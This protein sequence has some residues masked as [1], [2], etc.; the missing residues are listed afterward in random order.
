MPHDSFSCSFRNARCCCGITFDGPEFPHADCNLLSIIPSRSV[1]TGTNTNFKLKALVR[2]KFTTCLSKWEFKQVLYW[3]HVY[4]YQQ[5]H[6]RQIRAIALQITHESAPAK[7][8]FGQS[9]PQ[10]PWNI[11]TDIVLICRRISLSLSLWADALC[12]LINPFL[13][14]VFSKRIIDFSNSAQGTWTYQS[15][16]NF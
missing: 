9:Q 3:I 10:R 8:T 2:I 15:A 7:F 16:I 5:I 13:K 6:N 1:M 14:A 11:I 4:S 12:S